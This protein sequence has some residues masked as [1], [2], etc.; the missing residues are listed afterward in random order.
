MIV[1]FVSLFVFKLICK[2]H[3]HFDI[4]SFDDVIYL[5]IVCVITI[6][7]HHIKYLECQET[8]YSIFL[9]LFFYLVGFLAIN[10]TINYFHSEI[11]NFFVWLLDSVFLLFFFS[12]ECIG[13]PYQWNPLRNIFSPLLSSSD[14]GNGTNGTSNN[15]VVNGAGASNVGN[16]AME[17][18]NSLH[19]FTTNT[20]IHVHQW[21]RYNPIDAKNTA[22]GL[23]RDLEVLNTWRSQSIIGQG[24][25]GMRTQTALFSLDFFFTSTAVNHIDPNELNNLR[26]V[27]STFEINYYNR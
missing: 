9:S 2:N 17:N 22:N 7:L 11:V 18:G 15:G 1:L 8:F 4:L 24:Y 19:T 21:N 14:Q 23:L 16:N 6:L 3:F 25:Y 12:K 10:V 5:F 26:N 20:V 13:V 27:H